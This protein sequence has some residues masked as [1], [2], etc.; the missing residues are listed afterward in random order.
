MALRLNQVWLFN[1]TQIYINILYF[2]CLLVMYIAFWKFRSSRTLHSVD[3]IKIYKVTE[4]R[5]F[6]FFN[7]KHPMC[8]S[9]T[10]RAIG[11]K[12]IAHSFLPVEMLWRPSRPESSPAPS[13]EPEI[14][15]CLS[16][17]WYDR[18]IKMVP[19]NVSLKSIEVP[20]TNPKQ[21][22]YKTPR[23]SKFNSSV[24]FALKLTL[25]VR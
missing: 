15:H 25:K 17:K 9:K 5:V 14:S 19:L 18:N 7:S 4:Q 12:Q 16:I 20:G 23:C 1:Y 24:K 13:W 2:D 22:V 10:M 8:V 6:F 11:S 3:W 21:S